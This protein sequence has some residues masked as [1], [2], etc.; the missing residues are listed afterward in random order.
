M[1]SLQ[2]S[3][4]HPNDGQ[5]REGAHWWWLSGV[6][7]DPYDAC[8]LALLQNVVPYQEYGVDLSC[9]IS[10]LDRAGTGPVYSREM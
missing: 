6:A 2:T 8:L 4:R 5:M 3:K 9:V 1:T 10:Y 7:L